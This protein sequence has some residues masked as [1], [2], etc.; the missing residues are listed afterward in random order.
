MTALIALLAIILLAVVIL[1][2][3]APLRG[4]SDRT[5]G[6]DAELEDLEAARAAKYRE[7]RDAEL[8]FRTGKLSPEDYKAVDDS[9]RSEAVQILD[10]L[11]TSADRSERPEVPPSQI[12]G[13][14]PPKSNPQVESEA[15]SDPDGD[16]TNP[17]AE[18]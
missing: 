18:S 16:K 14:Q 9:L 10:R 15:V 7:I 8:D 12:Q 1:V 6:Q 4:R 11:E 13:D 2:V 3:S 5:S 17:Q